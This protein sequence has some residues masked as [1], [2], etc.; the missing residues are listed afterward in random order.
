MKAI[1][2]ALLALCLV[3]GRAAAQSHEGHA[4]G[5]HELHESMTKG[6][7]EMQSMEMSGDVDRDFVKSMIQHHRQAVEMSKIQAE[8]G[9]DAKAKAAAKKI[10][11][12]QTKEIK[13]LEGWLQAHPEGEGQKR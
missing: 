1:I 2:P 10:I 9:S 3:G 12:S 11:D 4:M 6:A 13:Q 7:Q 8:R 5:S